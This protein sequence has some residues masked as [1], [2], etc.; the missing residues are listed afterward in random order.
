MTGF[1]NYLTGE[2]VEDYSDGIISRREALRRLG[3]LGVGAGRRPAAAGGLRCRS[4]G[5]GDRL[6]GRLSP[7]DQSGRSGDSGRSDSAADRS[8]HLPRARPGEAARVPG[9]R[10]DAPPARSGYPR[11]PRPD[12]PFPVDPG[13]LAGDRLL[14]ARHRPPLREGGSAPVP[15]EGEVHR[16]A[17]RRPDRRLLADLPAGLAELERA[18]PRRQARRHRLLLRRWHGLDAAGRGEPRLAA[19]VPFYGPLPTAPTSPARPTP[20]CSASTPSTTNA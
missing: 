20:P 17:G 15:A 12:R 2:V 19:A 5:D 7:T 6:S 8:D 18:R 13:R 3:L 9:Q 4:A 1:N 14:R 16:R 11:E 10:G